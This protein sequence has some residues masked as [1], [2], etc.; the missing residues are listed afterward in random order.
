MAIKW[1]HDD[2]YLMYFCTF[3]CYDWLWLFDIVNGYDLVYKWFDVMKKKGY[4]TT[5]YVIMP[6]HLHVILYFP[7]LGF[8]L[9]KIIGNAKRFMAYEIIKRL[10]KTGRTD[11]LECLEE[12]VSKRERAKGQLHKVFTESFDA[13]GIYSDDFF[14]QKLDYIHLNPVR[15][16]W[17]LVN[18]YA[19]YEHSSA[20]FMKQEKLSS[21]SRLIFD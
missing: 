10:K 17:Q 6:N 11:I 12:S 3:T 13:K 5:G 20:S 4:Y 8:E 16:R 19:D 1:K 21:I 14:H 9:N 7:E 15:G 18:D 2:S